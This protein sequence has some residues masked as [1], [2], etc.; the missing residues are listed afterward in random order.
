MLVSRTSTLQDVLH[1][2]MPLFHS[3]LLGN[4]H[5]PNILHCYKSEHIQF[6]IQNVTTWPFPI[7][8]LYHTLYDSIIVLAAYTFFL[9]QIQLLSLVSGVRGPHQNAVT[10]L[11]SLIRY[12]T[13]LQMIITSISHLQNILH[14]LLCGFCSI[15]FET[16]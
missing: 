6:Q 15:T 9:F 2:S 1:I 13:K 5:L 8:N 7:S 3:I 14:F 12:L 16:Y 10:I 4:L 11:I